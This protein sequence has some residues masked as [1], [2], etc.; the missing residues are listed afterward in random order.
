M[1]TIHTL[2]AVTFRETPSDGSPF[3]YYRQSR[4]LAHAGILYHP[5][6]DS[7]VRV[8]AHAGGLY[9]PTHDGVLDHNAH[10][11]VALHAY[12]ANRG[13]PVRS[14]NVIR[15]FLIKYD[16]VDGLTDGFTYMNYVQSSAS[17]RIGYVMDAVQRMQR[18]W[19]GVLSC[20]LMR[21]CELLWVDTLCASRLQ[22]QQTWLQRLPV[23]ILRMIRDEVMAP[24]EQGQ[25]SIATQHQQQ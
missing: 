17:D 7:R 18:F 13:R 16:D 12:V 20:R 24:F 6:P 5:T 15:I 21:K 1:A 8:L 25:G 22:Q 3:T 2:D 11:K 4:M 19:R 10:Y 14:I 23:A 9:H